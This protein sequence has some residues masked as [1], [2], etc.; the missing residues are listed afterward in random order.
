MKQLRSVLIP[1]L[2]L[3][4]TAYAAGRPPNILLIVSDNQGYGDFGFTGNKIVKTSLCVGPTEP[5]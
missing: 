4:F 5:R 1:A 3:L 2:L